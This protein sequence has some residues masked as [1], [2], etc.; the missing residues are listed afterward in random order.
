MPGFASDIL[1]AKWRIIAMRVSRFDQPE[2]DLVASFPVSTGL[3][4]PHAHAKPNR[5]QHSAT[6][7]K[8]RTIYAPNTV[9]GIFGMC[10][11]K[12]DLRAASL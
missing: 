9:F 11:Y 7:L 12:P 5:G 6:I 1:K 3:D 10:F 4:R 8:T 2:N